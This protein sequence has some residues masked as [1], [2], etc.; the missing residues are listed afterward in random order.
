MAE[1][2]A[3]DSFGLRARRCRDGKAL[4]FLRVL[5]PLLVFRYACHALMLLPVLANERVAAP[6]LHDCILA[7]MPLVPWI[8]RWNYVLWL[9]CYVPPAIWIGFRDRR[10]FTRLLITDGLLALL[11]GL[12]IPLTG[13]GPVAC[14]DVNSVQAFR[15]WPTWWSLLNPIQA[16]WGNGA[17]LYLT[18]D[19]FF[20]GH[21]ATTFLLYLFSRRFGRVSRVFLGLNLFTLAVVYLSHLHYSIDV[22]AAYAIAYG[23]FRASETWAS[24]SV[25]TLS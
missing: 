6:S 15:F 17:N 22:I 2:K 25:L 13:L 12:V 11:R 1:R 10:L 9:L 8:A 18:K 14:M 24:R 20:S 23:V 3:W 7:H 21:I 5:L 19:L 16:I 4:G